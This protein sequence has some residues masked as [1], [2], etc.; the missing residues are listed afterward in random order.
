MKRYTKI[1]RIYH[2]TKAKPLHVYELVHMPIYFNS[3]LR[4][5]LCSGTRDEQIEHTSTW[6]GTQISIYAQLPPK[7]INASCKNRKPKKKCTNKITTHLNQIKIETRVRVERSK[8]YIFIIMR[9]SASKKKKRNQHA[10]RHTWL[11]SRLNWIKK[12]VRKNMK[13]TQN[14]VNM[15]QQ[16]VD[17]QPEDAAPPKTLQDNWAP[18]KKKIQGSLRKCAYK[19]QKVS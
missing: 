2:P 5:S 13:Q 3:R 17:Q 6:N 7:C 11:D 15:V 16:V 14:T 10:L 8:K 4:L 18:V 1:Y 12:Q 19:R 9:G